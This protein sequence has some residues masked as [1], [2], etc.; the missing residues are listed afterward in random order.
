MLGTPLLVALAAGLR[1]DAIVP[2]CSWAEPAS[3]K[4]AGKTTLQG[5]AHSFCTW[6]GA[7]PQ[8]AP[9]RHEDFRLE[10]SVSRP[11]LTNRD[12][13]RAPTT[14]HSRGTLGPGVVVDFTLYLIPTLISVPARGTALP[15]LRYE[16]RNFSVY[17]LELL[18]QRRATRQKLRFELPIEARELAGP[19][20]KFDAEL[21]VGPRWYKTGFRRLERGTIE[22]DVDL[23]ERSALSGPGLR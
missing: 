10:L 15:T 3:A 16:S 2:L 5:T 14:I 8:P 21:F 13:A 17:G 18:E 19:A 7:G 11:R 4:P 12:L 9:L 23:D 1:A 20:T 6:L 22:L